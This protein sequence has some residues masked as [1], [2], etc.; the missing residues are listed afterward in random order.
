MKVLHP[1]CSLIALFAFSL[2][3]TTSHAASA[4][5]TNASALEFIDTSFEN[6]SP[7]WYEFTTNGT[8][9]VHLLYDHERSSPN[10]AA[11]H[12]HFQLHA[13]TGSKLTLELKNLDNVWNSQHGSVSRELKAAVISQNGRDWTSIPLETFETDRTR[14]TVTMP[15]PSIFVAKI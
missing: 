9:Q 4:T 15:G 7:I 11:G 1:Y 5:S 14:V 2:L 10:R 13:P 8:I 3:A 6:A 12:F